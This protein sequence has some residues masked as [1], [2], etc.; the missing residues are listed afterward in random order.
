MSRQ[1]LSSSHDVSRSRDLAM[2]SAHTRAHTH[3]C[4]HAG[5]QLLLKPGPYSAPQCSV[6]PHT[7]QLTGPQL[8]P[9]RPARTQKARRHAPVHDLAPIPRE[10]HPSARPSI[11]AIVRARSPAPP[12]PRRPTVTVR[13]VSPSLNAGTAEPNPPLKSRASAVSSLAPAMVSGQKS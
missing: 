11:A 3:T 8:F 9:Q 4:S 10:C 2:H 5:V 13:Q 1:P 6:S 12:W 7:T